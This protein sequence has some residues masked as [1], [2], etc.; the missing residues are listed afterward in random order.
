[1][2][3]PLKKK[4]PFYAKVAGGNARR[5]A[6]RKAGGGVVKRAVGGSSED[7]DS[8]IV[9]RSS[10]AAD[11][12]AANLTPTVPAG[13]TGVGATAA[14]PPPPVTDAPG[15]MRAKRGGGVL[16][17]AQRQS[18]PRSDFALPGKGAGP[19]G[20]GSGSYPI[21][22]ESHARN[23]LARSSGKP[24]A[25]AVRAKVKAKYPGINVK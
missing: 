19:K 9:P 15:P 3:K 2:K 24:V 20:A 17:A 1:M 16:S 8:V 7:D 11:L 12:A 6:D 21:P 4:L 25:A 22:D 14:P 23:A 18:L 13:G 5:R 10:S